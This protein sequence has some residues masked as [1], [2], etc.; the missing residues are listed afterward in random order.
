MNSTITHS[1][2]KLHGDIA[3]LDPKKGKSTLNAI[4]ETVRSLVKQ[5]LNAFQADYL[6]QQLKTFSSKFS[7]QTRLSGPQKLVIER[8]VDACEVL[9]DKFFKNDKLHTYIMKVES[10][11]FAL[12]QNEVDEAVI[13]GLERRFEKNGEKFEKLNKLADEV[14]DLLQNQSGLQNAESS[15]V[16]GRFH[17]LAD[18]ILLKQ[19]QTYVD[20][21]KYAKE[22][23]DKPG[24]TD[25]ATIKRTITRL[26]EKYKGLGAP[27][28]GALDLLQNKIEPAQ[29]RR[30]RA[31][32]WH[33][34]HPRDEKSK[35]STSSV[36]HSA[37]SSR[38]S[39]SSEKF[40]DEFA[41]AVEEPKASEI[42]VESPK[43]PKK[44]A[45]E[46][47]VSHRESGTFAG[48]SYRFRDA[49]GVIN[50]GNLLAWRENLQKVLDRPSLT[51]RNFTKIL[52]D[53]RKV[54]DEIAQLPRKVIGQTVNVGN[55]RA[56]LDNLHKGVL[57]RMLKQYSQQLEQQH[58]HYGFISDLEAGSSRLEIQGAEKEILDLIKS[59]QEE[60]EDVN[61]EALTELNKLKERI[62][63]RLQGE[64]NK[65]LTYAEKEVNKMGN[66]LDLSYLPLDLRRAKISELETTIKRVRELGLEDERVNRLQG[67]VDNAKNQ[68]NS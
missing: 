39:L 30:Q 2:N 49:A 4:D 43:T 48:T 51:S 63:F 62:D 68:L 59:L 20:L 13:D 23:K 25:L 36:A 44:L 42:P 34:E 29:P 15:P 60:D 50:K 46:S 66:T 19:A 12:L 7:N 3:D 33:G 57:E 65:Q 11:F 18:K 52:A 26:I 58:Y 10:S 38:Q 27:A 64:V 37:A 32:S 5:E 41:S 47:S 31:A 56:D 55:L 35:Q 1:L 61:A 40:E 9:T 16:V 14:I 21:L 17:Q 54:Q 8:M 28:T 45:K 22:R 67:S 53:L 6:V 24:K